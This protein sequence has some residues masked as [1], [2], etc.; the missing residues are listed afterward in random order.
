MFNHSKGNRLHSRQQGIALIQ[1]L[2]LAS[3]L[4]VLGIAF[5]SIA[6]KQ[7]SSA[8][9]LQDRASAFLMAYSA[10]N[11]VMFALSTEKH[12]TLISQGWNFHG[13]PV[14]LSEY[15]TLELQDLNGLYSLP[16]MVSESMLI[17]LLTE[18][19]STSKA[20]ESATAIADWIDQDQQ[21]RFNGAEQNDYNNDVTVRNGPILT[22]SELLYIKGV[23]VDIAD[24]L[25][26]TTTFI[27]TVTFN[28]Y[29]APDEVL[30]SL[31]MGRSG[32]S[33]ALKLRETT[34]NNIKEFGKALG[35]DSDESTNYIVGPNYKI[36]VKANI[37]NSYY[38]QEI[39]TTISPY[40]VFSI[41]VLHNRILNR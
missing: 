5:T 27:P 3:L 22:Y 16:S 15:V 26:R 12:E 10:K 41:E 4:V 35:V 31:Y 37:N 2:I 18:V 32:V 13:K 34:P 8:K 36:R 28:P 14:E 30:Q 6:Q 39:D 40:E 19:T 7:V 17:R 11:E 29:S 24:Y 20:R 23:T 1:V 21:R 33:G 25:S 38:G 9:A